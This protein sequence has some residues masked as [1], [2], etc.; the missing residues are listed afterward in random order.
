[1]LYVS[2]VANGERLGNVKG[3]FAASFSPGS[4]SVAVATDDTGSVVVTSLAP[5]FVERTIL[6]NKN[7]RATALCWLSDDLVLVG[8][9][10]GMLRW[11]SLDGAVHRTLALPFQIN[12]VACS[13]RG[14]F[15]AAST[16]D[17]SVHLVPAHPPVNLPAPRGRIRR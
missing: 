7:E 5:P 10:S 6:R 14:D 17:G 4:N 12:A 9:E 15:F 11:I 1:V 16:A 13:P 3:G 2:R 8:F